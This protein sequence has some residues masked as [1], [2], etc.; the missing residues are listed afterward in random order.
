MEPVTVKYKCVKKYVPR[1]FLGNQEVVSLIPLK[2]YKSIDGCITDER[3]IAR[4]ADKLERNGYIERIET[5][6]GDE[7]FYL[8]LNGN[9]N[10]YVVLSARWTGSEDDRNRRNSNNMFS[11]MNKAFERAIKLNNNMGKLNETADGE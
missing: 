7:Y 3:G 10:E 2:I 5:A 1:V 6:I 8:E 9:D 11:S 4:L